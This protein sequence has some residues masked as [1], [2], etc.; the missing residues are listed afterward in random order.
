MRG[1]S[2]VVCGGRRKIAERL[3]DVVLGSAQERALEVGVGTRIAYERR[4]A[5]RTQE[6]LAERAGVALGT[7]RK[8][9]RGERGVSDAVLDAIA[10]A[11][12]IDPARLLPNRERPDDRVHRA[13]QALGQ[14]VDTAAHPTLARR[15]TAQGGMSR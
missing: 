2:A 12:D 9:E 14:A 11:L 5:N 15:R 4:I 7:I 3:K 6:Q 13:M 10:D 8:I 1:P